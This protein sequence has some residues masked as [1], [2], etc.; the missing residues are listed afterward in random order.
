MSNAA[1]R[2]DLDLSRGKRPWTAALEARETLKQCP[3]DAAALTLLAHAHLDRGDDSEALRLARQAVYSDPD[4]VAAYRLLAEI[5]EQRGQAAEVVQ[6][7]R[8]WATA[9]FRTQQS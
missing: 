7:H 4:C 2:H 6:V 8:A 3:S 1:G 9:A 5:H